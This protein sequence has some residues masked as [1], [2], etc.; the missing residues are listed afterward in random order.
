MITEARKVFRTR[1]Q[2]AAVEEPGSLVSEIE[3]EVIVFDA[4]YPHVS[5]PQQFSSH[6]EL[7]TLTSKLVHGDA[8]LTAEIFVATLFPGSCFITVPTTVVSRCSENTADVDST[9]VERVFLRRA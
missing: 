2:Y 5:D 1:F 9:V 3:E 6:I 7:T 4:A 8:A